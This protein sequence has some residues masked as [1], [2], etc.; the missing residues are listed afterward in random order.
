MVRS[1]RQGRIGRRDFTRLAI[2]SALA[3][4]A[5]ARAQ[6]RIRIVGLL[7]GLPLNDLLTE[8]S[9]SAASSGS[10]IPEFKRD[11][12]RFG[13]IE[14]RNL[15]IEIRSTF[16]GEAAR[17]AA[18]KDLIVLKADVMLTAGVVDTVALL[19]MTQTIP[20]VFGS[21]ADPVGSGFVSSLAR[22]GGNVTGYTNG[23]AAI[24]GKWLQFLKEANP[25]ISRVGV[26]FNPPSAPRAGRYFL[27]PIE[28]AARAIGVAISPLPV[29]APGQFDAAIGSH[30]GREGGLIVPPDSFSVVYRQVVVDTAARHRVTAIYPYR[31]F[32]DVG[33][34]MSYSAVPE[35][36]AAT[37]VNLIL[38]GAKAGDLPVQSPRKYELRINQ[39]AAEQLGLKLPAALLARADDISA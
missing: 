19:A 34:L 8:A 16:G 32:T 5:A 30:A 11:L 14:G 23:D 37:Y 35:V 13:W 25:A 26:L 2:A 20:I 24:G 36:K 12:A 1:D 28:E 27:D 9:S 29:T 21:A 22:P 18:I 4:P 31:Y 7:V 33:G 6:D 10:R 17:A 38:R 15:R 3:W 39:K